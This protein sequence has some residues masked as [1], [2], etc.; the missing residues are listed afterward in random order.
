MLFHDSTLETDIAKILSLVADDLPDNG[1]ISKLY[2]DMELLGA[3]HW[4]DL[5]GDITLIDYDEP[6]KDVYIIDTQPRYSGIDRR[7]IDLENGG[8][9][10]TVVKQALL[11][12]IREQTRITHS[13]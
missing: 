3:E 4:K 5:V 11:D 8:T 7:D 13:G 9:T 10:T 2:L 1:S 12:F 6:P